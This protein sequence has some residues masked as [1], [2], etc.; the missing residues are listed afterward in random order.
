MKRLVDKDCFNPN[1]IL[2]YEDIYLIME[3]YKRNGYM[4]T[5]IQAEAIW[6]EY[7]D[8]YCAGWLSL[9]EQTKIYELTRS[10][11]K[12]MYKEIDAREMLYNEF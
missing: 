7:S 6:S 2:Y 5:A 9:D 3:D 11:M 1:A 10:Y 4:L 8:S 12:E